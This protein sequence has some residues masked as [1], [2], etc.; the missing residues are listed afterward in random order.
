LI[1]EK[2]KM[3]IKSQKAKRLAVYF[4]S[5]PGGIVDA[6]VPC[7]LNDLTENVDVCCIVCSG[8]TQEQGK[9]MLGQFGEVII[10]S[11]K[12]NQAA[13]KE[14]LKYIGWE[15][16]GTF[17]EIILLDHTIMGPVYPLKETFQKMS[18]KETDF[19]S[20]TQYFSETAENMKKRRDYIGLEFVVCRQPMI[21][22]DAFKGYWDSVE[23]DP[24]K[25]TAKERSREF[26]EYF[27]SRGFNFDTSAGMEEFREL[28]E[29][30]LL[31]FPKKM[32]AVKRCPVFRI[33]N[34]TYPPASYLRNTAGEQ[35][36]ELY[37]YVK[38]KTDYDENLI[39][40][41]ILREEHQ[42]DI[43]KNL[44]L[45]YPLSERI[46][47][48]GEEIKGL[49]K[50]LVMHLYFEDL[51]E[52]SRRYAEAMP[53]DSDLYITT[54]SEKKKEAVLEVFRDFP[55]NRLEVRVIENRGRDVSSLL[56]GVKDV[57][58]NYD[59]ACFV[60]DKKTTQLKPGTIGASFGHKCLENTLSG[61]IYVENIIRT[62]QKNPR[63]GIL[64][65]PEP[66]HSVYFTTIGG[67]WGP[68]YEVTASLA[69]KLGLTVP[70]SEEKPPV[71]PMGTMFWFR[72]KAMEPLYRADWEYTDFPP[73]PNKA[74]GSLLHAVE[75]IYPYIVQQSGYY[76]GIVMTD[77]CMAVEYSNLRYY[78][79]EYNKIMLNLGIGP[80]QDEMCAELDQRLSRFLKIGNLL[81]MIAGRIFRNLLF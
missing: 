6:Y 8:N 61:K 48:E 35:T 10:S 80:Y 44:N 59:L 50:V 39:W 24:K 49:K 67:E 29:D 21:Q 22:S 46:K 73:E 53:P 70:I 28:T 5:D 68:N 62:F 47:I 57:I 30:P 76:P 78:T 81:K 20:V 75:R 51:L 54:S 31:M 42:S 15:K 63:L 33:Q 9:K 13:Y 14:G 19:W 11:A 43:V 77:A 32:V 7:L 79:R 55:C 2:R 27:V 56:T 23:E 65:P 1:G 38:D 72:P 58:M 40:D 26:T 71:C 66:N 41:K 12:S 69:K 34:F 45:V 4:F 74:D 18:E 16:S 64:S 36:S 25:G 60:H 17:D 52:E 37:N 3:R